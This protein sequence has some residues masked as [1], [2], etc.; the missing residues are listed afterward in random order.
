[1]ETVRALIDALVL[2]VA[3]LGVARMT[4]NFRQ[5]VKEQISGLDGR[6]SA[7]DGK[8]GEVRDELGSSILGIRTELKGD[9]LEL[10]TELK[11]DI[12]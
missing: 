8:L 6:V 3:A 2:A 9:I 10:R 11:G 4:R 7:V 5:E 12:S 1:M